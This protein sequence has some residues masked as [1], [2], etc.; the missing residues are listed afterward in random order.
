MRE[1][2]AG[3][4]ASVGTPGIKMPVPRRKIIQSFEPDS[5]E[6]NSVVLAKKVQ[7]FSEGKSKTTELSPPS[8]KPPKKTID[9]DDGDDDW[10]FEIKRKRRD[11]G[12]KNAGSTAEKDWYYWVIRVNTGDGRIV[13]FGTLDDLDKDNPAR[14]EKYW[15]RSA[16]RKVGKNAYSRR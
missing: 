3:G 10:R 4:A 15:K 11:A 2:A 8:K 7:S 16:K 1:R 13:Y 14:L 9:D 5:G 6:N 12:R